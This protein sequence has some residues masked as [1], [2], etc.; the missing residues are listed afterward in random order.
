M[1][2]SCKCFQ[3]VSKMFCRS[4]FVLFL[5]AIVLSVILCLFFWL[6]CCLSFVLFHLTIVLSV[7]CPFSFD[8]CVVCPFVLFLLAIV[9]SVL[10]S[11]FFWLLCCLSFVLFHLTIVLSVLLSFFFWLLCCLSFCPF[12]FDYCVV[13]PAIYGFF[14]L[15]L[16]ETE[17]R[18]HLT[19]ICNLKISYVK[20]YTRLFSLSYDLY[21]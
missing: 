21:M 7:L 13:C 10:L 5:L 9:L 6:L 20:T 11:F 16:T 12:S 15:F 18:L 19:R 4:L 8:Y 17:I 1:V 3:Q 2:W 14:K